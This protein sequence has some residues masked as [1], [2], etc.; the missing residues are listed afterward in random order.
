MLRPVMCKV[1][2]QLIGHFH[3]YQRPT[4]IADH[5]KKAHPLIAEALV[6]LTE[7]IDMKCTEFRELS[8]LS[9]DFRHFF[10]L[11]SGEEAL[12]ARIETKAD[13]N[14]TPSA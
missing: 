1:C 11:K 4:A 7:T 3:E 5:I 9:S 10:R 13:S 6:E 2:G 8:G 14:N 12:N